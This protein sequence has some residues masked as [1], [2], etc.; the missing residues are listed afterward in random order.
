MTPGYNGSDFWK[1]YQSYETINW[2]YIKSMRAIYENEN[3]V[4]YIK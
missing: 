3:F 4:L 1:F 2:D